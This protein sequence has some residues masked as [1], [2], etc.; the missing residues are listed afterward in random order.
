M[1]SKN[2]RLLDVSGTL[3]NDGDLLQSEVEKFKYEGGLYNPGEALYFAGVSF[4]MADDNKY[5]LFAG[6][7]NGL[8]TN[9]KS[10]V[11]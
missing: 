3:P 4:L 11:S 10:F 2:S 8:K 9:L 7:G 5:A 1:A 6:D